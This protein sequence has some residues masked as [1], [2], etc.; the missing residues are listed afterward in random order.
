MGKL[1][2]RGVEVWSRG[3]GGAV[4]GARLFLVPPPT[5]PHYCHCCFVYS[6]VQPGHDTLYVMSAFQSAVIQL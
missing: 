1:R 2:S 3:G 5:P 4:G 6:F